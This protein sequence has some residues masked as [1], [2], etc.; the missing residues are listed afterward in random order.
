MSL[1]G[2]LGQGTWP[3]LEYLGDF[4]WVCNFFKFLFV[5]GCAGSLLLCRLSSSCGEQGLLSS[6]RA[7]ASQRGG[8]FYGTWTLGR[9]GFSHCGFWGLDHRPSSCG[10]RG[11][12]HRPSNCG[13]QGLAHRPSSWALRLSFSMTCGIFP[14]QESNLC[15]LPWLADF[16]PQ[17][18]QGSPK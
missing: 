14:N 6:C 2:M 11:L 3:S 4:L 17:S 15:L 12:D 13:S 18:H 7:R 8:C 1:W 5:F 16:L 10:S 9:M